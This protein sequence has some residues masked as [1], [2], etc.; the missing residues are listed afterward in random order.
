[1]KYLNAAI[2]KVPEEIKIRK[3]S[4]VGIEDARNPRAVANFIANYGFDTFGAPYKNEVYLV[5][6]PT[7]PSQT[8][9]RCFGMNFTVKF[10]E[11]LLLKDLYGTQVPERILECATKERMA[12]IGYNLKSGQKIFSPDVT[13]KNFVEV[14]P[15]V[16][17]RV[18]GLRD[19]YCSIY[20][21]PTIKILQTPYRV[22]QSLKRKELIEDYLIGTNIKVPSPLPSFLRRKMIDIQN[23]FFTRQIKSIEFVPISEY[24]IEG[25]GQTIYEYWNSPKK[26]PWTR[27]LSEMGRSIEE[28]HMPVIKTTDGACYPPDFVLISIELDSLKRYVDLSKY[29]L[30]RGASQRFRH[31]NDLFNRSLEVPIYIGGLAIKPRKKIIK[32]VIRGRIQTYLADEPEILNHIEYI[33]QFDLPYIRIG[34]D[35]RLLP[36]PREFEIA[37][38]NYGPYSGSR[39]I[40]FGLITPANKEEA[41]EKVFDAVRDFA[42]RHQMGHWTLDRM[43][44]ATSL[45]DY[46]RIAS[47]IFDVDFLLFISRTSPE[48]EAIKTYS[49][50][51]SQGLTLNV[52]DLIH[53]VERR[54]PSYRRLPWYVR[55]RRV[56]GTIA[57]L[58]YAIYD[59]YISNLTIKTGMG[60]A[61]TVLANPAGYPDHCF[62]GE[63]VYIGIDGSRIP[64]RRRR[65]LELTQRA[66]SVHVTMIGPTGLILWT[67]SRYLP[68]PSI[69][70]G[71]FVSFVEEN[72]ERFPEK[73]DTLVCTFDGDII[74]GRT[75]EEMT[76]ASKDVLETLKRNR[77][78]HEGTNIGLVSLIKYSGR[79]IY[80]LRMERNKAL[81]WPKI[82]TCIANEKEALVV[83]CRPP[84]GTA[85]PILIKTIGVLGKREFFDA[86]KVAH[87]FFDLSWLCPYTR[88]DT[89]LPIMQKAAH[90]SARTAA[91]CGERPL[92]VQVIK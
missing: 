52:A 83:T 10:Q 65:Q 51:P 62:E 91:I 37:L 39:R 3:Y 66:A 4:I 87:Q 38:R 31:T 69:R 45:S 25:T 11:E 26:I 35:R 19:G 41:A 75:K 29:Q 5:H 79:R 17:I 15:A 36:I 14:H 46:R 76:K 92:T 56:R 23:V 61:L 1:M 70:P 78:A 82:G 68:S 49:P 90:E 32:D 12:G 6:T 55:D 20:M 67:A 18:E 16:F 57:S 48:W 73:I 13:E 34:R 80:D 9:I 50:V 53:S 42:L 27:R 60:G 30:R 24:E 58:A 54:Y 21:D 86:G 8:N 84:E 40:S 72:V 77:K 47:R 33:T 63:V 22:G 7:L 88:L 28:L 71:D 64:R 74:R 85:V 2:V 89:R 44:T 43:Y 81:Y 59:K